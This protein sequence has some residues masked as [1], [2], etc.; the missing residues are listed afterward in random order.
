M[1]LTL[2]FIPL[3]AQKMKK[4]LMENFIFCAV[5]TKFD[6]S[7]RWKNTEK[8]IPKNYH[9][10]FCTFLESQCQKFNAAGETKHYDVSLCSFEILLIFLQRMTHEA[11]CI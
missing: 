5:S 11:I 10:C 1:I 4:S 2:I 3:T 7:L 6:T 9:I 8:T